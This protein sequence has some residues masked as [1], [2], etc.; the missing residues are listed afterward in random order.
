MLL[1]RYLLVLC[2]LPSS[3]SFVVAVTTKPK[4]CE[5]CTCNIWLSVKSPGMCSQFFYHVAGM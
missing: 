1:S 2:G 3:L 4:A 5:V